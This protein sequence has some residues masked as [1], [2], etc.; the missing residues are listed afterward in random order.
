M[1]HF[2]TTLDRGKD[3]IPITL[4]IR[5][6]SVETGLETGLLEHGLTG[7]NILRNRDSHP[8][9]DDAEIHDNLHGL[10]LVIIHCFEQNF[11]C[12]HGFKTYRMNQNDDSYRFPRSCNLNY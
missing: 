2:V 7:D 8:Q 12:P 1:Y 10:C 9:R 11:P 6:I 4:D 3:A 5:P